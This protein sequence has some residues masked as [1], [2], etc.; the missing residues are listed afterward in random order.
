MDVIDW[1]MGCFPI[2]SDEVKADLHAQLIAALAA[3][4]ARQD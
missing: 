1:F 2:R 4:N 3:K